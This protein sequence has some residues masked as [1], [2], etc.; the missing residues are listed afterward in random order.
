MSPYDAWYDD[1]KLKKVIENRLIYVNNVDPHK[2]LR[3]FNISKIAPRVSKFNPVLAKYIIQKYLNEYSEIFDPFSGYSGRLL[4]AASTL[5]K[6][7]IG[8][9]LNENV[10][11]ESKQ[12]ID[13]LSI[14]DRCTVENKDV[15]KSSGQY[16][17]LLT[18]PPYGKKEIYNNESVFK[19][20][21]GWI[22]ECLS[23]FRCNKYAFVVD[24]TDKYKNNIVEEI[25]HT[26][27]F[28]KTKEYII[29]V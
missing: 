13:F 15:L 27:H 19:T 17:C 5:N 20:C 8:Q 2:I 11:N 4:G 24:K 14:N 21:D 28:N 6:R 22:D 18:C 10:V 23:R 3:G 7:Y 29:V 26:S 16:Q 25:N 12:I 1:E 9:D